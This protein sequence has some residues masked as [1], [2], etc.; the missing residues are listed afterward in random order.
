ML[1]EKHHFL[2]DMKTRGTLV[3]KRVKQR[4]VILNCRAMTPLLSLTLSFQRLYIYIR[5]GLSRYSIQYS[6][7]KLVLM[8]LKHSV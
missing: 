1:E 8:S 2:E 6:E 4:S 7:Q 3:K 5:L